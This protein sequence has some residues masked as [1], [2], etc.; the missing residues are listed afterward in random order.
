MRGREKTRNALFVQV[1]V[2]VGFLKLVVSRIQSPH[3]SVYPRCAALVVAVECSCTLPSPSA[4][5]Y[6]HCLNAVNP[7]KFFSIQKK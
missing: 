3:H 5:T 4:G 7:M 1:D 2:T 6:L